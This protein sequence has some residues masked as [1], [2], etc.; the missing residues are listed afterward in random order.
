MRSRGSRT[1]IVIEQGLK[2]ILHLCTEY[3]LPTN[4]TMYSIYEAD[5]RNLAMSDSLSDES[6]WS[7]AR[8]AAYFS[9]ESFGANVY[10]SPPHTSPAHRLFHAAIIRQLAHFRSLLAITCLVVCTLLYIFRQPLQQIYLNPLEAQPTGKALPYTPII[11][12]STAMQSVKIVEAVTKQTGTVIF[13]HVRSFIAFKNFTDRHSGRSG[14]RRRRNVVCA[15]RKGLAATTPASSIC[16]PNRSDIA[17][18]PELGISH[19]RVRPPQ[20]TMNL[21]C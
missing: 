9:R 20:N 8:P 1:T 6:T 17:D 12:D 18:H 16:L 3:T 19:A 11:P 5:I 21:T 13:L 14:S 10:I 7:I 4:L 2:V 15:L